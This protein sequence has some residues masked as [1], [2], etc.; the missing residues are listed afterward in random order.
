SGGEGVTNWLT[1]L[2][3]LPFTRA[4]HSAAQ[5]DG[6]HL[7]P[8]TLPFLFQGHDPVVE[9]GVDVVACLRGLR[10]VRRAVADGSRATVTPFPPPRAA[11]PTP[12]G[13]GRGVSVA[14][15]PSQ[16]TSGLV[17]S[18]PGSRVAGAAA[19]TPCA[20]S[21]RRSSARRAATSSPTRCRCSSSCRNAAA[22]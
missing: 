17:S 4:C 2:P 14:L 18:R 7:L 15:S 21:C 9:P 8:G 5:D 3:P 22:W 12:P 11:A 19:P 16:V 6:E 13:G 1:P 20:G 10:G